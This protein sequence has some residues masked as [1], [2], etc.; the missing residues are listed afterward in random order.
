MCYAQ[1]ITS[2]SSHKQHR[3]DKGSVLKAEKV[4][5]LSKRQL[6]SEFL[7]SKARTTLEHALQASISRCFTG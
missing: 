2:V 1:L 6:L 7:V 3:M 5:S 4:E